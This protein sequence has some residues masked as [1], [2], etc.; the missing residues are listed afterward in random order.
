METLN[1]SSVSMASVSTVS[2]AYPMD[3]MKCRNE[4]ADSGKQRSQPQCAIGGDT[5]GG[6]EGADSFVGDSKANPASDAARRDS[7]EE[8]RILTG[9]WE[10]VNL[11]LKVVL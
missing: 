6:D 11:E 10:M 1:G 7:E 4:I 3:G 5:E 8:M 2:P 9:L